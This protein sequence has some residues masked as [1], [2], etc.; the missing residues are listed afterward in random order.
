[1]KSVEYFGERLASTLANV[2]RGP[3]EEEKCEKVQ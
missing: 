3:F 2:V 1:M